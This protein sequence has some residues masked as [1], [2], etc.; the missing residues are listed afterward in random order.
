METER[1]ASELNQVLLETLFTI[2]PVGLYLLDPHMRILRFNPA[3]E[4]MENTSVESAVGK[5]PTEVWPNSSVEAMEHVMQQV[6]AT[7]RPAIGVEKRM[8]PPGDPAHEHIYT[9]SVF[10]LVGD[11]GRLLGIADAT[12]DVTE[13]ELGHRRLQ[14]LALAGTRI[15]STLDV[16]ENARGLAEV[17]VPG[18]AD[19]VSV[20]VLGPVLTGDDLE[21]GPLTANAVLRCAIVRSRTGEESATV[22]SKA[23]SLPPVVAAEV[24]SDLEPR[25]ED[26]RS[27]LGRR[28]LA[29]FPAKGNAIH[30]LLLVP[31]VAQARALGLMALC[32]WG[33]SREFESDDLTL[34][35][36]LALRTA[37][38]F[39]NARRITRERNSVVALQRVVRESTYSP[40][41][42]LDVAYE[43]V[44]ADT[45][46]DWVDV[47]PLSSARIALVAGRAIGSGLQAVAAAGR[48]R[49]AVHTLSDLDVEPD[50]LMARLNDLTP[51]L[52]AKSEV[53]ERSIAGRREAACTDGND[54][55]ATCLYIAYDPV[56]R[57][58]SCA[59]AG[60]PWPVIVGPN[61]EEVAINQPVGPP[62]G[63][64]GAPFE[65]VDLTLAENSS[66][67]LYTQGLCQD[68]PE[69]LR[70]RV[71]DL[72]AKFSGPVGE[73]CE[74][75]V[76]T[77][78][79]AR[80]SEDAVVQVARVRALEPARLASLDLASELSAVSEAR[81]WVNQ[82]LR[83]WGLGEAAFTT[84]LVASE[85]VTNAIRY[86]KPPVRLRLIREDVLT[87]EVSDGSSTSPRL[88]HAQSMDEGGRGL[89]LAAGFSERWG[90]RY[91]GEGKT[92]WVEQSI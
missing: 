19:S 22:V 8:R 51:R 77:L 57:C 58:C 79:P 60:H 59:S 33:D 80:P 73:A 92:V 32:R 84:E 42:T 16:L 11:D 68:Q 20:D 10:P 82:R 62:L 4:G 56:V 37:S 6:L 88:R 23:G 65:C 14:V 17:A 63:S 90:T 71:A 13:R 26:P 61:G 3:A 30:S 72:L 81:S 25:M 27:R 21:P 85:L 78:T 53:Q 83:A 64:S 70:R 31:L 55:G 35:G 40:R 67:A 7:R 87:C 15:G 29:N 52:F 24:L 43:H 38:C 69:R 66:L 45:G 39:D 9:A 91:T 41:Q 1:S 86:A 2:S 44:Q 75:I 74:A 12:V 48:I 28:I 34:A 49:A 36:E 54:V 50:E 76:R 89:L 18:L 5:R 47:I 46:G